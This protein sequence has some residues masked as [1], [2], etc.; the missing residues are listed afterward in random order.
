MTINYTLTE[1][2]RKSAMAGATLEVV[3]FNCGVQNSS[4]FLT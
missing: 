3:Y 2:M 1:A 4:V